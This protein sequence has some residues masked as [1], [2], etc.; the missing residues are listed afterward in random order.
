M[1]MPIWR[2]ML[3][4]AV[5]GAGGLIMTNAR[6]TTITLDVG[7]SGSSVI[8]DSIP[9]AN[10]GDYGGQT[11]GDVYMANTLIGMGTST[12]YTDGNGVTFYRSANTFS[13]LPVATATGAVGVSGS[14][15][16]LDGTYATITLTGT[17]FGYLV[18]KYDGP[19]GGAEVWNISGLAAD[20]VIN[21]PEYAEPI[22]GLLTNGISAQKY[23]ITGWTLLNPGT[24]S[25]P[26]GGSTA[27]LLG[28]ALAGLG[29]IKRPFRK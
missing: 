18:A 26:D 7:L 21:I 14:G 2:K 12:T 9:G 6:A 10:Y 13:S 5:V 24:T 29:M 8:G 25:V 28:A 11:G 22:N 20:T 4:V 16:S 23:Q 27:L 17:G 19:N 3:L 15:L 1:K